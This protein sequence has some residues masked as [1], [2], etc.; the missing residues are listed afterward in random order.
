MSSLVINTSYMFQAI[1][2]SVVL[3]LGSGWLGI[4]LARHFN[5]LDFPGAASA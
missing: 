2:A 4:K 5:L 3:T 1:L